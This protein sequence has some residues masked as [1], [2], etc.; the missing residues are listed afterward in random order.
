VYIKDFRGLFGGCGYPSLGSDRASSVAV[1]RRLTDEV[2]GKRIYTLGV[3]IGGYP[4]LYY[5]L[6][7]GAVAVLSLAGA[8]DLSPDFVEGLGPVSP[9]Y[10][11]FLQQA[12]D[13][14]KDLREIYASAKQRPHVLLA[15][16][17][18]NLRDRQQ[19]ERMSGLPNVELVAV[20]GY[21]Q[22]NV[23]DPLIRQGNYLCLLNRL[24]STERIPTTSRLND[25]PTGPIE[26]DD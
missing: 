12:P 16:G 15:F 10:R 6:Q 18:G 20:D 11:N 13:Y 26:R 7:L 2:G 4:A 14:A 5:G 3:S 22:H 17:G 9:T 24:L 21:T 1:L 23:V 19:A 25:A 8:T